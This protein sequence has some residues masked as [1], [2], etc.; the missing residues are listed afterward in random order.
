MVRDVRDERT[1]LAEAEAAGVV[2]GLIRRGLTDEP[3]LLRTGDRLREGASGSDHTTGLAVRPSFR[4]LVTWVERDNAR[5][6]H[7]YGVTFD[8]NCVVQQLR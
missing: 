6:R 5:R 7:L 2:A 1:G 4:D 8:V 3:T